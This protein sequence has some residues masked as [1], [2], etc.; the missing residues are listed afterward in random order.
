VVPLTIIQQIIVNYFQSSFLIYSNPETGILP[1]NVLLFYAAFL[2]VA[3]F[4]YSWMQSVVLS[5]LML[6]MKG[7]EEI[8]ITNVLGLAARKYTKILGLYLIIMIMSIIGFVL[9][10][11]PGIY[12]S[13]VLILVPYIVFFEDDPTFEAIAR[14]FK[15]ISGKWWSTFGLMF[16]VSF[17]VGIMQLVFSIP[18]YIVTMVLA[19]HGKTP[20]GTF[21]YSLAN[22]FVGVGMGLLYSIVFLAIGFQYFNLV[23]RRESK[24]LKQLIDTAANQPA[25][26]NANE[27]EY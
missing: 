11:I 3:L 8:K 27:G 9:L 6:Y 25:V 2:A 1:G 21:E 20:L 18:T 26:E 15:L 5:Y 17:I 7:P 24:G 14:S 22:A 4:I 23:E 12:L 19:A 10:V 13:V 16:V